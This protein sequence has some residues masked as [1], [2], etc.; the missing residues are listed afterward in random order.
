MKLSQILSI[1]FIGFFIVSCNSGKSWDQVKQENNL[2]RYQEFLDNNPDTEHKDSLIMFIMQQ[3]WIR[4]RKDTSVSALDSFKIK[5]PDNK[6]YEDSIKSM[7][8]DIDWKTAVRKNTI[9]AFEEFLKEYSSS[10]YKYS[11]KGKIEEILWS[12]VKQAN[13]KKKYMDFLAEYTMANYIDSIDF[14]LDFMDLK[15]YEAEFEGTDK[16]A[17]GE[18]FEKIVLNFSSD[19]K[20]KGTIE[21]SQEGQNYY[22]S[23]SYEVRGEFDESGFVNLESR[24]MG[25]SD[26]VDSQPDESWSELKMETDNENVTII[27][28]ERTYKLKEISK[29][30]DGE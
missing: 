23:W 28:D 16:D 7:E 25:M 5:Y 9:E 11:A 2:E 21:G 17:T 1:L 18:I 24:F 14:K 29:I 10:S 3:E 12:E 13:D 8:E 30:T 19:G 20:L 26:E 4:I 22:N 6:L 15:G 27:K